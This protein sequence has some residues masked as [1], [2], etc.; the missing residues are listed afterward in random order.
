M[1]E[2]VGRSWELMKKSFGVLKKDKELII[3]PIISTIA[4]LI[5]M[6][7]FFVPLFTVDMFKSEALFYAWIFLAYVVLYFV[8][9]FF[10]AAL[11][12]AANIRLNGGDPK[13][14]DGIEAAKKNLS[15]IFAWAIIAA[16]VGLILNIIRDK[17]KDNNWIGKIVI[18]FIGA[19]WNIATYF[20]VPVLVM[21][22]VGPFQ[23]IKKSLDVVKNRFGETAIGGFGIGILGMVLW[24]IVV[25]IGILVGIVGGFIAGIAT[26][27]IL[28][29]LVFSFT[30]A[31]EGIYI[32]ALYNYAKSGEDKSELGLNNLIIL[33]KEKQESLGM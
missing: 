12:G 19:A 28:G 22:G 15:N 5:L 18:G 4:T 16:T 24:L 27:V 13:L 6:V 29:I 26:V 17:L 11:I 21:E 9:I 7:L 1:F 30:Q 23:A 20:V 10:N 3:F 25:G 33:N 32:A 8:T 2:S 31:L 14:S